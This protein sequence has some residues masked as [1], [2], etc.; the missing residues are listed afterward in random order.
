MLSFHFWYKK[1][2]K[3]HVK[4]MIPS[5][6]TLLMSLNAG[7]SVLL[8]FYWSYV[9]RLELDVLLEELKEYILYVNHYQS[10]QITKGLPIVSVI[11]HSIVIPE[12]WSYLHETTFFRKIKITIMES[13]KVMCWYWHTKGIHWGGDDVQNDKCLSISRTSQY[14]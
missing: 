6:V 7:K 1:L 2:L 10:F 3:N 11:N 5:D 13:F 9:C 4:Q 14:Q 12:A 8:I